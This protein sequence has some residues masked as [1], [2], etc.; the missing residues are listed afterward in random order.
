MRCSVTK[1]FCSTAKKSQMVERVK[2]YMYKNDKLF[3]LL[4]ARIL[5]M[6][7]G[8][9]KVEMVVKRSI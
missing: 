1:F 7:E 5:E 2:D 3:E 8:Y 9:A 6:K 4:D